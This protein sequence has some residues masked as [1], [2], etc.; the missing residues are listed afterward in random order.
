[1]YHVVVGVAPED[2]QVGDKV[3]AITGLPGATE[4]V[5]AT[6]VHFH[7]GDGPVA[8]VPVVAETLELLAEAGVASEVYDTD[9]ENAPQGLVEVAEE[10]EADLVCI[11][12]RHRSPAGKLQL[13]TGAQEIL[14]R[15]PVPVLVAGDVESREPRT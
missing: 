12:G 4:A 7:E 13:K 1:M 11:G 6:V 5:R 15:A 3:S 8:E 2:D 9:R 10:L 14:L